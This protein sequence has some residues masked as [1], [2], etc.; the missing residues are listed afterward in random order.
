M[1]ST[2]RR[3]DH[4]RLDLRR[5]QTCSS[6]SWCEKNSMCRSRSLAS[7]KKSINQHHSHDVI[8]GPFQCG[9][10]FFNSAGDSYGVFRFE[11]GINILNTTDIQSVEKA[12]ATS[13]S[14]S[15]SFRRFH[16][17]FQRKTAEIACDSHH[18]V[19]FFVDNL[20]PTLE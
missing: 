17:C 13:H 9:R 5:S 12:V 1:C 14:E 3:C 8:V 16:P 19:N 15:A 6:Q 11:I 10:T 18:A 7:T 20:V 4:Y 2:S